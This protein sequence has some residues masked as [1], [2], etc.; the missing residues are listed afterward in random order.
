[1]T[2]NDRERLI[3]HGAVVLFVGL[4]CGF[5]A[6]A[7]R[8]D[9]AFRAWRA[10]HLGLITTG[11]WLLATAAVLPSLVLPRREAL[12]LVWSLLATGYGFMTALPIEAVTGVRATQPTGSAA[13][14]VAFAGNAIGVLGALLGVLLTLMGARAALKGVR[15]G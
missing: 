14:W 9:E 8:G 5:P 2:N 6:L 10:A 13:N 3:F 7:E 4:L 1:M 15:A 12:A 11:I